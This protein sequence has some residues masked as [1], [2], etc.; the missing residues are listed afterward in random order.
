MNRRTA[1]NK[2][3]FAML[4][5]DQRAEEVLDSALK[6]GKIPRKTSTIPVQQQQKADGDS[7][8]AKGAPMLNVAQLEKSIDNSQQVEF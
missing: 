2:S 4:K 3:A 7:V 1:N 6:N 8:W 5:F